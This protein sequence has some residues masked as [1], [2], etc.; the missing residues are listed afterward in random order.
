VKVV[1]DEDERSCPRELLEQR[2]YGAMAAVAL[3]LE[4]NRTT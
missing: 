3:V 1:E 4:R 2:S